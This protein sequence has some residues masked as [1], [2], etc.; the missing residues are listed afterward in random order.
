MGLSVAS[1]RLLAMRLYYHRA[2]S[3]LRN[4]GDD[5]NPWLWSRVLPG[6]IE[7]DA[8]P[9]SSV[10][11]GFG[12][13]LN[14]KLPEH[15][16]EAALKVIF[17]TGVGYGSGQPPSLGTG[18]DV[19][20]VRG[21][22][23]AARLGLDARF[24]VADGA[25]LVRRHYEPAAQKT[26]RYSFMPHVISCDAGEAAW[27]QICDALGIQFIDPQDKIEDVLAQIS[28]SEVLLAEAMHGA[29]VAD[30]LGTPWIAMDTHGVHRFKW[31]D[32]CASVG[33]SY[34]PWKC[35]MLS[36]LPEHGST[37]IRLRSGIKRIVVERRLRHILSKATPV[38]SSRER[39][40]D[41]TC[42]LEELLATLRRDSEAGLFRAATATSV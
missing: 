34:Q 17:T 10:L 32:W 30:A 23:S 37:F 7:P 38:L 42:Q 14:E 39:M 16:S 9:H 27:R 13:L 25:I 40:E 1:E 11:I 6:I 4:F 3:G 29:I 22:L 20:S 33:L 15:L 24:G 19:R 18:W 8:A 2:P 41:L 36:N 5:L 35:P 26:V 28:A 31:E 21:P 12:T